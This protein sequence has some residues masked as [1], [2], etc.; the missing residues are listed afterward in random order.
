VI[1]ATRYGFTLP[2]GSPVSLSQID[3]PTETIVIF[4][5]LGTSEPSQA[6]VTA[7]SH[8]PAQSATRVASRH[9]EGFNALYADG[10]VKA[11]KT[12]A[13]MQSEWTVQAD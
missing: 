2:D 13:S 5:Y 3:L 11:R 9:L 8:L 1:D 4:D 7:A 10:H 12:S 6:H